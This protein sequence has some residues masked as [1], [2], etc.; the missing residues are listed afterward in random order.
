MQV[1]YQ[2]ADSVKFAVL[3]E[4]L[5]AYKLLSLAWIS[6]RTVVFIDV[7]EQAHVIDVQTTEELEVVDLANVGLAY[8]T[9]LWKSVG[10]SS[11]IGRSLSQSSDRLCYESAASL[12]GQ[13]IVLGMT[14]IHVFSVRTWI[15]RL[16]VLV[17]RRQFGDALTLAQSFYSREA[18]CSTDA[19]GD[20]RRKRREAVAE[21]ILELLAKYLDH[22]DAVSIL[23]NG[24][25]NTKD[26]YHVCIHVLI[27][28]TPS[29][30]VICCFIH[31]YLFLGCLAVCRRINHSC[32]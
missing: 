28:H 9:N 30:S 20:G 27:H 25:T 31:F 14:G 7:S 6:S 21:R 19:A 32:M 15:E 3:K 4:M 26:L 13:L 22:V 10:T 11:G 2:A 8:S 12:G 17:R 5:L 1:V 18:S 23:H 29:Y 24:E 16:N